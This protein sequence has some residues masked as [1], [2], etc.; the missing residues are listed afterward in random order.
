VNFVNFLNYISG[1]L[2]CHISVKFLKADYIS[3]VHVM[4]AR[5]KLLLDMLF[6]LLYKSLMVM[7]TYDNIPIQVSQGECAGL[8]ENVP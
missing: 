4:N 7:F 3:H 6:M 2:S 8:R 5:D 1:A